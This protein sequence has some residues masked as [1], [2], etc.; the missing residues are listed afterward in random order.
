MQLLTV[1]CVKYLPAICILACAWRMFLRTPCLSGYETCSVNLLLYHGFSTN[2]LPC[3]SMSIHICQNRFVGRFCSCFYRI[4]Y[5]TD[6]FCFSR[7]RLSFVY[8]KTVRRY[9]T[10]ARFLIATTN[11]VF[12]TQGLRPI[13]LPI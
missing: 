8:V 13:W 4:I 9:Q 6:Y 5:K 2:A 12:Q 10:F 7:L 11:L 3:V 1:Q